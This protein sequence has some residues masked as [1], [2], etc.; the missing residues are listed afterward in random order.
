V[1]IGSRLL[2]WYFG[3]VIIAV[4]LF[5]SITY[6]GVRHLLF[7]GLERER[8]LI[9][10]AIVSHFDPNTKTFKDLEV[11]N[12]YFNHDMEESYL[13]IY[14]A[15]GQPVYQS[16]IADR[17]TL[18][19]PMARDKPEIVTILSTP[20]DKMPVFHAGAAQEVRLH[21]VSRKLFYDGQLIGWVNVASS[22]HDIDDA[23]RHLLRTLFGAKLAA[24]VLLLSGGYFLTRKSLRPVAVMT[25]KARTISSTNLDERIEIAD[26]TDEIGQLALVLNDLLDRLQRAFESQQR[27]MADAAHELKTP[28]TILRTQWEDELNNPELPD[29]FKETLVGDIETITRLSRVINSLLL[30]SQTES[31]ETSFEFAA[32]RLDEL[33]TDVVGDARVLA[34]MK[35]QRIDY[36]DTKPTVVKGDRD[37]L[38]Q[39]VFNLIDNAIKYTPDKGT[40]SVGLTSE[41]GFAVLT[42]RDNGPGIPEADIPHIFDRFYRIGKDRSRKTGGS[43]LGLA[44]CKM[45]AETLTQ[46]VATSSANG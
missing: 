14:N 19:I 40:I 33:V 36:E 13:V 44:I 23:L 18:S 43:G 38:Y 42:I 27:F 9:V 22:M 32:L 29:K 21:A 24:L 6:V 1:K 5:S 20:S 31:I 16:P 45:V 12:L 35:Q 11:E 28:V 30:L 3:V 17:I 46:K 7:E 25:A 26:K 10:S 4:P 2:L 15:D 8:E 37:R 34:D 39:L 41:G